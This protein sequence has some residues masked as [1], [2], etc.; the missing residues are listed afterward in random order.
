MR[1]AAVP[2]RCHAGVKRSIVLL[3][4]LWLRFGIYFMRRTDGKRLSTDIEQPSET[5][6]ETIRRRAGGVPSPHSIQIQTIWFT[7]SWSVRF[8]GGSLHRKL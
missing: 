3:V 5:T 8:L 4:N 6:S 7:G 1:V 2:M